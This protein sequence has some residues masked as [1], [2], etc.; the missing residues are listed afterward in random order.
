M[1]KTGIILILFL[2]VFCEKS[3]AQFMASQLK[4]FCSVISLLRVFILIIISMVGVHSYGQD[5]KPD[6]GNVYRLNYKVD[7]PIT[8]G[9][10]ALNF[11]GLHLISEKPNM[12][13]EQINDLSTND[14]WSFDRSA[15]LQSYSLDKSELAR[16]MSDWG[17]WISYCLPALLFIDDEI[18][19]DWYDVLLLYFETQAINLNVYYFGGPVITDRVRPLVYYPET[20][21]E[22]KLSDEGTTDSFFSGHASMTAGAFFFMAKVYSDYHPEL[23]AKKWILYAAAL[24]P[25]AFV[26]FNRYKGLMH[27]PTDILLGTAI[28]AGVGVLIPQLHKVTEMNEN[29]SIVPFTGGYSGVAIALKF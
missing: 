2:S 27:F 23:G 5:T 11:Y 22:Y 15:V 9:M 18:R 29:L 24:I 3:I 19:K 6:R 20:S 17:L 10:F 8:A 7:V 28:G 12:T 4:Q 21:M 13:V 16:N 1:K 14:I 25:P 26:G